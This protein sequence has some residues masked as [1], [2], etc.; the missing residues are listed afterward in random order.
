MIWRDILNRWICV[1]AVISFPANTALS[2]PAIETAQE[3]AEAILD[4][5]I[6]AYGG[7]KKLAQ[8]RAV[9]FKCSGKS[10]DSIGGGAGKFNGKV[11]LNV[12]DLDN[13]F[14]GGEWGHWLVGLKAK[15]Y[16]MAPLGESKVGDRSVV[17]IKVTPE[18]GPE[19]RLYF[20]RETSLLLKR[21]Q[22]TSLQPSGVDLDEIL[23]EDYSGEDY[24]FSAKM[25]G[26]HN[27]TKM[28]EVQITEFKPA[29]E[30]K[31]SDLN[32]DRTKTK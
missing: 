16:K 3:K 1:L 5:S 10:F 30:V 28:I 13:L 8:L 32:E 6:R 17:G 14:S 9:T 15:G 25:T 2:A 23:Y 20:D 11:T 24:K 7:E 22:R 26:F 31:P 21:E 29:E 18:V 12:R 27:G 4:K 19:L